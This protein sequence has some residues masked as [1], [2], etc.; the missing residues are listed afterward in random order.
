M[1][2]EPDRVSPNKRSLSERIPM[3][4]L[5]A[6]HVNRVRAGRVAN[7]RQLPGASNSATVFSAVPT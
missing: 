1:T 6:A 3:A 7:A 4:W 2:Y 5:V